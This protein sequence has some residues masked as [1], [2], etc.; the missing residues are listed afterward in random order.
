MFRL[1]L[2]VAERAESFRASGG[3]TPGLKETGF[4]TDDLSLP[5]GTS[6]RRRSLLPIPPFLLIAGS[7]GFLTAIV[8][9]W[10]LFVKDPRASEPFTVVSIEKS[11]AEQ[12]SEP[13]APRPTASARDPVENKAAAIPPG[14]QTVTIIDGK[15][16]ARQEVVVRNI[17]PAGAAVTA[18]LQDGIDGNSVD[19]R[20]VETSRHG[21]IPRM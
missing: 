4:V 7:L 19:A 6:I 10:L 2:A 1:T 16:G 9:G 5:L 11:S 18:K 15:S 8:L 14:A 17:D 3:R 12:K 21:A 20:L 13:A